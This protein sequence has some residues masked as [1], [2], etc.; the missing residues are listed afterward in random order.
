LDFLQFSGLRPKSSGNKQQ[1]M[2]T[3]P[4]GVGGWTLRD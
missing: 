2:V 3:H 4:L 1:S